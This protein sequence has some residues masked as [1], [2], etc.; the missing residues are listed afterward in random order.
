MLVSG[1]VLR[2]LSANAVIHRG[3]PHVRDPSLTPKKE[4]IPMA[5]QVL[6]QFVDDLDGAPGDDVSTVS[7]ALDGATYEIDLRVENADRLRNSLAD[8]VGSARRVGGRVKRA[9]APAAAPARPTDTR[10][11]EQ[12]KAI[13][14][15]AKKNGFELADRGRIPATVIEAFEGAHTTTTSKRGRKS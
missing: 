11:K 14:E 2:R 5:Q 12:T 8:Y 1:R 9:A 6:V 7:F 10:S 3:N 4:L 13:R 15:W